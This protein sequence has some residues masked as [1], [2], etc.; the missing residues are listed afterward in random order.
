V[1]VG[2]LRASAVIQAKTRMVGRQLGRFVAAYRRLWSKD[3]AM[4]DRVN[5]GVEER[6][7]I[8]RSAH[9]EEALCAFPLARKFAAERQTARTSAELERVA[10]SFPRK[11]RARTRADNLAVTGR[12]EPSLQ[13]HPRTEQEIVDEVRRLRVAGEYATA[14][15]LCKNYLVSN[16]EAAAVL[17]EL[18]GVQ[19]A[20][21]ELH[22]ACQAVDRSLVVDS[23][24]PDAQLLRAELLLVISRDPST[25]YLEILHR[26]GILNYEDGAVSGESN[27]L[28][29]YLTG[30]SSPV[31]FDVGAF[32]GTYALDV[33][34]KCPGARL[35]AFEPNPRSYGR[36]AQSLS[37]TGAVTF[38]FALGGRSQTAELFDYSEETGSQHATL[39]PGIFENVHRATPISFPVEVRRLDDIIEVLSIQSIALLK[40]DVEGYEFEVLRG[41]REVIS[42]GIVDIIQFEFNEMNAY[43]SIFLRDFMELLPKYQFYRLLPN[44]LLNLKPYQPLF[45]EIFAFQNII[46]VRDGVETPMLRGAAPGPSAASEAIVTEAV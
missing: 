2:R 13:V 8:R 30:R 29:S 17:L 43:S 18:A 20:C 21:G 40:I 28:R 37:G 24:N 23:S 31:V 14:R 41:A 9:R 7:P 39:N 11:C 44:D 26:F 15:E 3:P 34:D 16:P 32:E 1:Q 35:Y 22:A 5:R 27:F 33:L 25:E 42:R 46:C 45:C 4:L 6:V 12:L 36:L 19:R 38:P 10:T